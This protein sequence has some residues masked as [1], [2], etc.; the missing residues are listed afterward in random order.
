MFSE[1]VVKVKVTSGEYLPKNHELTLGD[2]YLD[3]V[4]KK[5]IPKNAVRDIRLVEKKI[6]NANITDGVILTDSLVDVDDLEPNKNEGIFPIPKES[7]YAINGSLRSRDKVNLYLVKS[8]KADGIRTEELPSNDDVF[9]TDVT[10]NYVR[11]DDNNDVQD[12]ENGNNNNRFTSTGKVSTP[13]LKMAK[14]DG[15]QLKKYLEQGYKLWIVRV[16]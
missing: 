2:V 15:Q 9:L 13:E 14:T 12:S 4:E 1:K 10:V 7:I 3:S 5:D 11:T 16:E 8:V 6:L